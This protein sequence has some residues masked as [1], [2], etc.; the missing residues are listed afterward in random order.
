MTPK[1]YLLLLL[2][3][4]LVVL[5]LTGC[6]S[7]NSSVGATVEGDYSPQI[8]PADFSTTVDNPF[9]P[10]VPGT[11]H[12]YELETDEGKETITVT[13]TDETRVVM[14]VTCVVVRDT[15]RFESA[16]SELETAETSPAEEGELVE[17]TYDWF[18]QDSAGNVWY[19]GEDSTE[20]EDGMAVSTDGSWEAGVDGSKPGIIMLADPQLGD[21]YRQEYYEG[22]AEDMAQV[23]ALNTSVMVPYGSFAGCLQTKEWTPLEPDVFEYK[24]YAP[25]VGP[26]AEVNPENNE[27]VE[28]VDIEK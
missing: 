3:A 27:W 10:L 21:M 19:F 26:V 28:L 2:L 5:L 25:G 1:H 4:G 13:V 6:G 12:V 23:V 14:G 24:Y 20:Y 15:V 22:E 7:D 17:D 16:E 8:N 9:L 18:A 11:T